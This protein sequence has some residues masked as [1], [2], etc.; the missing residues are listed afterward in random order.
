MRVRRGIEMHGWKRMDEMQ[1]TI[2]LSEVDLKYIFSE[3]C[4][5][6]ACLSHDHPYPGTLSANHPFP[7]V[8]CARSG[9]PSRHSLPARP[10]AHLRAAVPGQRPDGATPHSPH[11]PMPASH[12]SVGGRFRGLVIVA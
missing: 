4:F 6:A 8:Q 10:G 5:Q 9:L 2:T 12:R 7:S 3:A 1:L 11:P